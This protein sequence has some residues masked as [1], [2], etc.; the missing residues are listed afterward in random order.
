MT[1]EKTFS[2]TFSIPSLSLNLFDD[3]NPDSLNT[4]TPGSPLAKV[5]SQN[6]LLSAFKSSLS[7]ISNINH[8]NQDLASNASSFRSDTSVPG[9]PLAKTTSPFSS[10]LVPVLSE[11]DMERQEF[12]GDDIKQRTTTFSGFLAPTLPPTQV[13]GSTNINDGN[14]V[15]LEETVSECVTPHAAP[16][17]KTGSLLSVIAPKLRT[18]QDAA[19][20]SVTPGSFKNNDDPFEDDD[21]FVDRLA[22]GRLQ[23]SE[24]PQL[25]D[26]DTRLSHHRFALHMEMAKTRMSI[27]VEKNQ[28]LADRMLSRLDRVQKLIERSRQGVAAMESKV[29]G[30]LGSQDP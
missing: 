18:E 28:V 1:Q 4:S 21:R 13:S 17:K 26:A 10:L 9:S 27:T 14:A 8:H 20:L 5:L 15:N 25:P 16:L 2:T 24:Q 6:S 22:R 23:W 11:N 3:P 7:V 29:A 12:S 19:S 30:I